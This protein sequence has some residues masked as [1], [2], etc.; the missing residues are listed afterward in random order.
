MRRDG[1]GRA[2]RHAP[3]ATCQALHACRRCGHMFEISAPWELTDDAFNSDDDATALRI[4]NTIT[5][6]KTETSP[7]RAKAEE[8]FVRERMCNGTV[9]AVG[10]RLPERR[11]W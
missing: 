9:A 5:R 2:P 3:L 7:R 4:L 10:V 6:A 1:F 8:M 11:L